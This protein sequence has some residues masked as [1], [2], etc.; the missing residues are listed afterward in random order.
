MLRSEEADRVWGGVSWEGI[1]MVVVG[2]VSV[3]GVG[4]IHAFIVNYG[5]RY[6]E[7]TCLRSLALCG[8]GGIVGVLILCTPNTAGC[9]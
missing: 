2:F 7:A 8:M 9:Q 6:W 3:C 5:R 4:G 1:V